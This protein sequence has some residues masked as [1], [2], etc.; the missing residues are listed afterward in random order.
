MYLPIVISHLSNFLFFVQKTDTD[1]LVKFN[2]QKYLTDKNINLSFYGNNENKIWKQI[3]K[4]IGE[5]NTKQIK[6]YT[7]SLESV[8]ASHW[9]KAS[10]H[11]L[12][13]RRYF[14]NNQQ[15]FQ[16]IIFEIKKLSGVKY[17]AVSKIP[18]YL[19]S[20]HSSKDKEINAW[21]SWTPKE[22]FIVIEIPFGL[23]IPNNFFPMG[24]LAH[25]FFHLILRGNKNLFS[26]ISKIA[27]E[28]EKLFAKLSEGMPDRIFLEEL[29]I[30]SFIPEGYLSEKYFR[31]KVTT[32]IVKPKSLLAWRKF[33]AFKLYQM[34]KKY[35]NDNRQIDEK[36]LQ[37]L[38]RIIKQNAK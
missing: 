1:Y 12:L 16:Q 20:D 13:W 11:L 24:V 2:L 6:K 3:E 9:P 33:V 8:F 22:S 4:A 38:M 5:Q 31:A 7:N 37:N 19:I 23:R 25:E 15:L 36:Y 18:I 26:K 30:S 32:Y 14:Q 34:V 27:K 10:K 21:F 28:N 17:F 29:M 35:I